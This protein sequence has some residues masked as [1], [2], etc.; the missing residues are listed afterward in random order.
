MK[1]GGNTEATIQLKV[2]VKNDIGEDVPV[3]TMARPPFSGW[4]D[5]S[6]GDSKRAS[7]NAK[8]Q[9]STHVFVCDY[10]PLITERGVK[11]TSGNSRIII[12]NEVYEVM[13]YDNPMQMNAQLEIY[14]KYVGGQ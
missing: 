8:I 9:E 3:W 6:E 1:I 10:F 14:V 13:L 7:F 4:L 11:I 2:T 5:L 12:N